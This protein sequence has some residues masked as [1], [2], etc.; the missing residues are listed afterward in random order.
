MMIRYTV[1]LLLIIGMAMPVHGQEKK[2]HRKRERTETRERNWRFYGG[3]GLGVSNNTFYLEF[4]PGVVYHFKPEL[5][6][7]GGVYYAYY[8]TSTLSGKAIAHIYGGSA[9]AAYLPIK[10]LETSLEFQYL[11][12]RQEVNG[13]IFH[14]ESPALYLGAGYRTAHMVI[15]FRYDLLYREGRSFYGTAFMPFIRI[16]F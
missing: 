6:A 9:L 14:R 10:N 8:S 4:Y 5:Y 15:G 2:R 12:M 3:F 1:F 16:Y 7:G 13:L 11:F